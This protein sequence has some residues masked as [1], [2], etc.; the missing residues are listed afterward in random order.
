[1]RAGC[2]WVAAGIVVVRHC[3]WGGEW[4]RWWGCGKMHARL[5]VR[6]SQPTLPLK[7]AT[8]LLSGHKKY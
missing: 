6:L 2:E 7:L 5:D 1:M 3:V 8:H 4:W